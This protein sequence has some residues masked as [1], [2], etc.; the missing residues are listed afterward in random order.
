MYQRVHVNGGLY[1][2]LEKKLLS[3]C[4]EL[5]K[6]IDKLQSFMCGIAYDMLDTEQKRLMQVQLC[7]MQHYSSAL[8]E[9]ICS[10]MRKGKNVYKIESDLKQKQQ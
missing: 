4:L 3:E 2:E 7:S 1:R 10:L 8:Q 6:K 9:R 5:E